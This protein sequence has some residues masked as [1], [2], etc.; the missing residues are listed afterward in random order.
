M[1]LWDPAE[2]MGGNTPDEIRNARVILWK[3]HCSVHQKF[4]ADHVD[5]FRNAYPEINIIAH[6]EC[7]FDVVRK[8]DYVGSTQYIIKMVR[9]A[10][11]G[12]QWAVGTEHHLVNR[13][14]GQFP[15]KM[16][17]TLSPFTCTCST[18]YRI[19]PSDL[20]SCMEALVE[21]RVINQI[22]V[23][24][25]VAKWARVALERMLSLKS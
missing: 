2:E 3:G 6:P 4:R 19:D 16:V 5:W 17:M 25:D 15:E 13:L 14:Q 18:M 22:K 1:I 8:A 7:N 23:R 10:A 11:A 20:M 9:E 12:S 24:K 21:G